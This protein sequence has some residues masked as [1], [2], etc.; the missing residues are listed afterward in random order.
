MALSASSVFEVRTVGDD[1]NGGGFVTG[2]SGTDYSQQDAKNTAGSNIS[3]TDA[4]G[5][6]TT[7]ITSATASFTSAIVGNIIYL[8]GGTGSL[9]AGRYQV[10]TFTNSITIVVDRIVAAGTGI[11][12]NIGGAVVSLGILG[13]ST[14]TILVVGNRIWIKSGTYTISSATINISGGCFSTT[15]SVAIEGYN[16]TR[17]DLGT[18]PIL[19][20]GAGVAS[21]T[22][23]NFTSLYGYVKNISVDGNAQTAS[24]GINLDSGGICYACKALNCINGGFQSTVNS[25][26]FI[27]CS[28]TGCATTP[29]FNALNCYGCVAFS[30]TVTGFST[31][32]AGIS[33][34]RNCISYS[35]TGATTD[36]FNTNSNQSQLINC[37]AYGNGRQG[38]RMDFGPAVYINCIAEN[39][40]AWGFSHNGNDPGLRLQNCAGYNNTS[41]NVDIGT[42]NLTWNFGFITGSAS[43][44]TAPGSGDFSL[45]NTAGGGASARAAGILGVFPEGLTT[46]YLDVGAAQHQDSG[47]GGGEH[48]NVF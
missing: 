8:Q 25:A 4:V 35:N 48:S 34:Y 46:G 39:N 23:I 6:G 42:G 28:A 47:G 15:S 21:A 45:N 37:V 44:F 9:A 18:K 24:K 20:V 30:N 29:A 26:Q 5:N 27:L 41:G 2:A 36:G 11:T 40:T 43:F 7:T 13:S 31:S 12:M 32:S 1:T 10:T 33:S 19:Q 38:F 16:S 14:A 17:G 3:T 22:V